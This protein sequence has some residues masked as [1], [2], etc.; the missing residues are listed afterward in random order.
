MSSSKSPLDYIDAIF[1]SDTRGN[2]VHAARYNKRLGENGIITDYTKY[3]NKNIL[4]ICPSLRAENSSI[5]RCLKEGRPIY[6][7][8]QEAVN[9]E[10][11]MFATQNLTLPIIRGGIVIGAIELSKDITNIDQI[12]NPKMKNIKGSELEMAIN[13]DLYK[14][15]DIITK[16]NKMIKNIEKAKLAKDTWSP[17]LIYGDTGTGKELYAQSIHSEGIRKNKPFIA[18]NCAALPETLFESILFGSEKG[19]FTGAVDKPGLFESAN[20]GTLFLDEINSMPIDLQA[21]LL[22]VLENGKFRRIGGTKDISVN[23]KIIAAMN[24]SPID[25]IKNRK[26]RED[27]F[28]RLNVV[29]LKLLP[30]KSRVEDIDLYVNYFIEKFNYAMDKSIEGITD[31][32]KVLFYK[33]PWPGN[34]RELKHI[35]ESASHFIQEG[36]IN[37][38]HLPAYLLDSI[39]DQNSTKKEQYDD[40]NIIFTKEKD[41]KSLSKIV[42]EYERKIILSTL[43]KAEGNV[44]KAARLLSIPRQTLKYKIQKHS[45]EI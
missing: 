18:Q 32:V 10:N 42:D 43:I 25:A 33:Y 3:I 20:G 29:S 38:Q 36:N 37:I 23:V 13:K 45:I 22:R 5:L 8:Y 16:N 26:L 9:L 14:F 28:Y 41:E 44:S 4:E 11:T 12:S 35:I 15:Q 40:R 7:E 2:I 1:I 6:N 27:L 30:L 21:K 31:Q 19:A 24:E 34:V 17:V 39:L